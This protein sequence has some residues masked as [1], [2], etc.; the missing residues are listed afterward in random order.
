MELRPAKAGALRTRGPA[1]LGG[2]GVR[3]APN[4]PGTVAVPAL[5]RRF[6]PHEAGV[7]A[8]APSARRRGAAG[9]P[10]VRRRLAISVHPVLDGVD[11][12]SSQGSSSSSRQVHAAAYSKGHELGAVPIERKVAQDVGVEDAAALEPAPLHVFRRDP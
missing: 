1:R 8:D 7:A 10:A 4:V 2:K 11:R 6:K 3:A 9:R 5:A 12:A